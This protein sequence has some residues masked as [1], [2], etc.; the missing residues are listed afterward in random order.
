MKHVIIFQILTT[1]AGDL[2]QEWHKRTTNP[3]NFLID[4]VRM[5]GGNSSLDVNS[6]THNG[7]LEVGQVNQSVAHVCKEALI[8]E[9]D[10]D[11]AWT[12]ADVWA[13]NISH[14]GNVNDKL[15]NCKW[16]AA[17]SSELSEE[18]RRFIQSSLQA[19]K[20]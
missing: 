2:P 10:T 18:S 11:N 12:E 3:S 8:R 15:D 19:F 6:L 13:V 1:T 9:D 16:K 7:T 5:A 20:I 14:A 4:V 17:F